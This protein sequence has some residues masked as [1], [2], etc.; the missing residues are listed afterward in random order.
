MKIFR[1]VFYP[2]ET[3]ELRTLVE[4]LESDKNQL[5]AQ[6][7]EVEG[8]KLNMVRQ[9]EETIAFLKKDTAEER[10]RMMKCLEKCK[11]E[12]NLLKNSDKDSSSAR[13]GDKR[14]VECQTLGMQLDV[15][16][17][18]KQS[19]K[20]LAEQCKDLDEDLDNLRV[21]DMGAKF[22]DQASFGEEVSAFYVL[23]NLLGFFLF[24]FF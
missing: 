9:Y 17:N 24:F 3:Q 14:S 22:A 15:V 5:Q 8:I 4:G 20:H 18:L 7:Q 1:S 21:T 19:L 16:N 13:Y 2:Q 12:S 6:L 10:E 23:K 11:E